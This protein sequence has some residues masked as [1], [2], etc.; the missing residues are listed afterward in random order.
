[1]NSTLFKIKKGKLATWLEWCAY[2]NNE[3][4]TAVETLR[5]ENILFEGSMH[6]KI[7]DDD[8]VL[9]YASHTGDPL[10]ATDREINKLHKEKKYECFE[11]ISKQK[12]NY[13][14]TA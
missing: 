4:E 10:P 11:L 6:F 1:M 3:K 7:H 2:L 13:F 8:Y 14:F 5:E 12:S 9:L